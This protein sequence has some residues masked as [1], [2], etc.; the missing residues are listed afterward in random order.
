MDIYVLVLR[1]LHI[2]GGVFWA[3]GTFLLVGYI[4]PTVRATGPE[5]GKFMQR[6]AGQSG[7]SPAMSVAAVANV[8]AGLLLYW[9][10]SGG[11]QLVWVTTNAGLAFTIGGLAGLA[12]AVVGFAIT[13]SASN[14]LAQVGKEIAAA[15]G[16]PAPEKLAQMQALQSKIAHGWAD[17][18][19][20]DDR[21]VDW[22]VDSPLFVIGIVNKFL[23]EVMAKEYEN[24]F[25]DLSVCVKS[26]T[27][28]KEKTN[29][30]Q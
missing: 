22:H 12:A 3:G 25:A 10:D 6:F 21:R 18:C 4:E 11:L 30:K 29:V 16:P 15:G 2:F 13:G 20:A 5:G 17:Q 23:K 24:D 28:K 1:L 27:K 7:F 9:R 26:K 14:Q 19:G 8:I